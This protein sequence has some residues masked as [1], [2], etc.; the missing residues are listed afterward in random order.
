MSPARH[1]NYCGEVDDD[2]LNLLIGDRVFRLPPGATLPVYSVD[3]EAARPIVDWLRTHYA[4]VSGFGGQS[5]MVLT[6]E[7]HVTDPNPARAM[8]LAAAE[9]LGVESE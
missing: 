5:V 1:E 7:R 9:F 4:D 6:K 8:C 2:R 3:I